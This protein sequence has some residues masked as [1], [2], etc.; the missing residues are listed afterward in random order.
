MNRV[1]SLYKKIIELVCRECNTDPIMMFSNNKEK[2]VDARG[3]A[4]VLLTEY[5]FS[6]NLISEYSGLTQ[7]AVNRLKNIYPDRI[8]RHF[9]LNGVVQQIHNELTITSQQ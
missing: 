5:K 3:I 6:E 2:N 1:E 8:R 9:L 4:I 7:Q